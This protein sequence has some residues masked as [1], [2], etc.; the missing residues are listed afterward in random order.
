MFY[1][2][3]G[4]GETKIGISISKKHGGAVQR[5]R[6]KR[7][8]RAVYIPLYESIKPSYLI[9]FL[10]KISAEYS[11][12]S[13]KRSVEFLLKKENLINEDLQQVIDK[14]N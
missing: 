11:Y 6:I 9:V 14:N 13:F 7:L 5:N 1:F 8:L 10:P 4:S 12:K 2:K 3:K